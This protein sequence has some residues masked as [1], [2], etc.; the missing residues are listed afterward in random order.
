MNPYQLTRDQAFA[1]HAALAPRAQA[2]CDLLDNPVLQL[3]EGIVNWKAAKEQLGLHRAAMAVL[4]DIAEG[5]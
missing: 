3:P 1:A 5:Q 2:L 4:L